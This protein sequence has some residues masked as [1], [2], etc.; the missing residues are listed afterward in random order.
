MKLPGKIKAGMV[1]EQSISSLD[2]FP[3]AVALAGG[4]LPADRAYDGL[5]L[6]P[7]L[8]GKKKTAPLE[9]DAKNHSACSV[10]TSC[11]CCANRS[12]RKATAEPHQQS[13]ARRRR[14]SSVL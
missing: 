11:F 14:R 10:R 5:D 1:Y 8:T 4:K 12:R 3:T 7:Y 6:P 2:L 9:R 13:A